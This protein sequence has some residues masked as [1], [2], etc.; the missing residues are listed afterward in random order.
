MRSLLLL[1]TIAACSPAVARFQDGGST[2]DA[3]P[4]AP[5]HGM[6][7]VQVF[8]PNNTGVV[9]TGIPVVFV[10]PDGTQV[11]HP[12]TD[13]DGVASAEVHAG[14]SATAVIPIED[15]TELI[16]LLGLKP[17]D[18]IILGPRRGTRTD[19]GNFTVSFATYPG[20]TSYTVFGPCGGTGSTASPIVLSMYSDCK[21]DTM[22]LLVVAYD[23]NSNPLAS[24]TKTGVTFAAGGSTAVTGTYQGVSNFTASYTNIPVAVTNIDFT[25]ELPDNNGFMQGASGVPA[26][27][28][29]SAS[30]PAPQGGSARVVT[31][32]EST[33]DA[34]Q[35][36]EQAIQGSALTYGMDVGAT[37][38]PW[39]GMP[40]LDVANHKIS[41]PIDAT[42]TSGDMPDVFFA[43]ASYSRTVD[44]M[45]HTY[46][47]LVLGPT[48]GDMVLPTMPAEVG[49]V[50]PKPDDANPF[51]AAFSIES[52]DI[53]G[54]DA[55]RQDIYTTVQSVTIPLHPTATRTRQC[56]NFTRSSGR[57]GRARL[58]IQ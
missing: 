48:P 57:T 6:V 5:T 35:T 25:R 18:D 30:I 45:T 21:Q 41:V 22:D 17:G 9:V 34:Q 56:S 24:L 52:D 28:T 53:D 3:A 19:A 23:A 37:L 42:G 47:W 26:S 55:I 20:A 33:I 27:G 8:D 14:A 54:Y 11:G 39:L 2:D 58:P 44:T 51:A 38:L 7:R 12:V 29:Y 40:A 46:Q 15:G 36:I 1:T 43:E 50:M 31:N 13:Q 16:T 49:D 10:D 4:D 32:F